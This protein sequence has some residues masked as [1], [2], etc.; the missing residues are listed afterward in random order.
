MSKLPSGYWFKHDVDAR[1]DEKIIKLRMDLGAEG[2][3]IYFMILELLAS[4]ENFMMSDDYKVIAYQINSDEELVEKVVQQYGLF[5]FDNSSTGYKFFYSPRLK[6]H[7]EE[8]VATSEKRAVAGRASAAKRA[9][10][11]ETSDVWKIPTLD[12]VKDYCKKKNQ[13]LFLNV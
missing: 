9:G 4:S 13:K 12:E 10:R 5:G 8:V 11:N 1:N 6:T 2:Y 3:G 7:M